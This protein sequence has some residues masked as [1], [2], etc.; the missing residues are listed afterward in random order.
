VKGN[1]ILEDMRLLDACNIATGLPE[2]AVVLAIASAN[3]EVPSEQY[4]ITG[5]GRLIDDFT[6]ILQEPSILGIAQRFSLAKIPSILDT[7]HYFSAHHAHT[8]LRPLIA[9]C[10]ACTA[11]QRPPLHLSL[12]HETGASSILNLPVYSRIAALGS[13]DV[14]ALSQEHRKLQ[15]ANW[16]R[17]LLCLIST[18]LMVIQFA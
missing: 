10:D 3:Q 14:A 12:P 4:R 7:I 6:F 17:A 9:L 11:R 8:L 18:I 16:V 1:T 15:T 13:S 2:H 5:H